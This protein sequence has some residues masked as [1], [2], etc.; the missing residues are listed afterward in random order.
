MRIG[1][2]HRIKLIVKDLGSLAIACIA[3]G[4][5]LYN[6]YEAHHFVDDLRFTIGNDFSIPNPDY[7]NQEFILYGPKR[8]TFINSGNRSAAVLDVRFVF[9]QTTAKEAD[10]CPKEGLDILPAGIEPFVIKPNEVIVKSIHHDEKATRNKEGNVVF[11]M[12][13]N[14]YRIVSCFEFDIVTPD[15]VSSTATIPVI[16][17]ELATPPFGT[18]DLFS[19]FV[20][21]RI[22]PK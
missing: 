9:F 18:S 6:F 12:K 17:S 8:L 2:F 5:S 15:N 1:I 16:S 20:P 13:D 14:V 11:K 7:D 4:L 22:F 19:A 3:L 21:I 10:E